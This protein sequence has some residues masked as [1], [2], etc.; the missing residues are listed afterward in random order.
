MAKIPLYFVLSTHWDREWYQTFQDYRYR[1]VELMDEILDGIS[2]CELKGPFYTDGQAR[3]IEDYLEIRPE[4]SDEVLEC[5]KSGKILLGPWYLLPD[6]FLVSGESIIR[7]L[8]LGFETIRKYGGQPSRTGFLCDMF[9]HISQMPQILNGFDIQAGLIWRGTNV[10]VRNVLWQGADGTKLPTYVFGHEGYGAYA[11]LVRQCTNCYEK[12]NPAQFK[13]LLEKFIDQETKLNSTGAILL[14]DGVD[15]QFWDKEAYKELFNYL[16][17]DD[18]FDL[19]HV[20]L[21]AYMEGMIAKQDKISAVIKSELR[22]VSRNFKCENWLIH[23]VLSSRVD[24]KQANTYCQN[25]LCSWA[26]PFSVIAECFT[27]HKYPAGFMR[28]AWKW[29]IKNHPHDSICGCG[30]DQIHEDM[31][32]RFSQS[33]QI[34]E[35]L[36]HEALEKI[37]MS[38]DIDVADD[39]IKVVVFNPCP[40][41]IDGV[42]TLPLEIP[43]DWPAYKEFFGFESLPTFRIYDHSGNELPYQR[44]SQK[45]GQKQKVI[46]K[47]RTLNLYETT[48]VSVALKIKIP[49]LGYNTLFLKKAQHNEPV[50]HPSDRK[51]SHSGNCLENE[52]LKI[53]VNK[54]GSVVMF[55][56]V[57]MQTYSDMLVFEENADIGDGW[58]HG[59]AINDEIIYSLGKQAQVSVICNG[60]ELATLK[61]KHTIQVPEEFYFHSMSR[62][63][64]FK[65]LVIISLLTLTAGSQKLETEIVVDN[66]IKDHRL[67]VVFPTNTAADIYLTD[68]VFDVIERPIKLGTDAYMNKELDLETRPQQ[69][70]T[71][72]SDKERG[73]AVV[74]TG[75]YEACL[76]D[77]PTKP[78]KLTLFRSTRRTFTTSG[79][80]NGQ[81]LKSLS[82][83]CAIVPM[84]G[85][86]DRIRLFQEAHTLASGIK[87]KQFRRID[88]KMTEVPG[89]LPPEQGLFAVENAVLTSCSK[90][91]DKLEIRIFNPSVKIETAK[92]I[93]ASGDGISKYKKVLLTNYDSKKHKTLDIKDGTIKIIC[94]PKEIVTIVLE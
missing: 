78:I 65:E 90:F 53:S 62:G 50:R 37:A 16:A 18:R 22:D 83:K 1:L 17:H 11:I 70:W 20:G 84:H 28:T 2:S 10:G 42:I 4:R 63:T 81:L 59:P 87:H 73:L 27:G 67:R 93:A 35:R 55:D 46:F 31:I 29:L 92:I 89:C 21:D 74:S 82:F 58:Y 24:I 49:A 48:Q 75:L 26:E 40:F 69:T 56:K 86:I 52:Y 41:G 57:S 7:N 38:V 33:R 8:R 12:F 3:I 68:S 39:Q 43:C 51:I 15:H 13:R 66:N 71:A 64:N 23:G 47:T 85:E 94:N 6:E 44:L 25:I 91:N 76:S 54:D 80:P 9:G 5:I 79:E 14:F 36:T 88:Q 61:V 45:L 34:G 30:I 19:R 32:Y 72:I 77:E 60:P